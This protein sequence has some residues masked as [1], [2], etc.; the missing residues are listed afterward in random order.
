MGYSITRPAVT[1]NVHGGGAARAYTGMSGP[2]IV[3]WAVTAQSG[4]TITKTTQ[5]SLNVQSGSY[6]QNFA[7]FGPLAS[8]GGNP[9]S[10]PAD[11]MM[12]PTALAG[13]QT[14]QSSRMDLM[15]GQKITTKASLNFGYQ[16]YT[17]NAWAGGAAGPAGPGGYDGQALSAGA[18]YE[19]AKGLAVRA[20]YSAIGSGFRSGSPTQFRGRGID[21]GVDFNKSLSV[22]RKSALG[23][24][25]GATG[26]ADSSNTIRYVWTGHVNYSYEMGRSWTLGAGY[27]RSADFFTTFGQPVLLDWANVGVSGMFGRRYQLSG[28]VGVS[29]GDVLITAGNSG[30]RAAIASTSMRTA[31]TRELAVSVSY[32]YYHYFV[33]NGVPLPPGMLSRMEQQSVRVSLEVWAPLMSQVR[34]TNASR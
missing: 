25:T 21:A 10:S 3:T 31:L 28:D 6:L 4:F 23:F 5:L 14:Y 26:Y 27:N 7:A 18:S 15:F 32:S 11:P 12:D 2:P 22:T 20:G 9:L 29:R 16:Y 1:F 17:N 13:G 24:G 34:R 33:D 19:I 8:G 30:Y